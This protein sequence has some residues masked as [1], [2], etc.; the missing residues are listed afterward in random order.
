MQNALPICGLTK[1]TLLDY[2]GHVA[3]TVFLGGCNFR[4]PFC[5]NGQLV[6]SPQ[7]CPAFTN[8]D[9]LMHLKKRRPIL[10]GVCISGGEPTLYPAL[11]EFLRQIKELEYPVK[12]DTNGSNPAFLSE[13]IKAG[14]ID[15]IA[16]DIKSDPDSYP[17]ACGLTGKAETTSPDTLPAAGLLGQISRS[18]CLIRKCGIPYEVRTTVVKGLHTKETFE[19]IGEWL[20]GSGSYYLQG[21]IASDNVLSPIFSSFSLEEM[22]HF[23]DICRPHFE[24]VTIRGVD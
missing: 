24:S 1:T 8:E 14:L 7:S 5:H 2:P 16:M 4:C 15:Y 11:T 19:R 18:I 20:H 9:I 3:S 23:A 12:L 17:A 6:L 13:L 21:Y 22:E 10:S